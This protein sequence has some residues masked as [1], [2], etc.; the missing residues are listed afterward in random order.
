AVIFMLGD[1]VIGSDYWVIESLDEEYTEIDS[2]GQVKRIEVN[3]KLKEYI[4]DE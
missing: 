1:E 2:K 3:V 4:D